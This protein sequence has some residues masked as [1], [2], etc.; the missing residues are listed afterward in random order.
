[1]I[2]YDIV[3]RKLKKDLLQT[4]GNCD[5]IASKGNI[6]DTFR[7]QPG[8]D[9][10]VRVGKSDIIIWEWEIDDMF[11]SEYTPPEPKRNI[12]YEFGFNDLEDNP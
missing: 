9:L 10:W 12:I 8:K 11:E 5:K 4:G 3:K 6:V 2:D 1:M 7:Y